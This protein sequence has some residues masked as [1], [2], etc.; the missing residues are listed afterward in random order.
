MSKPDNNQQNNNQQNKPAE[1]KP[2]SSP[3][4]RPSFPQNLDIRT[5]TQEPKKK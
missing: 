1:N 2:A 4:E 5:G 3:P